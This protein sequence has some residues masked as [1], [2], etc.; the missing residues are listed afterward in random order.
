MARGG[1]P[2]KDLDDWLRA[3]QELKRERAGA[4]TGTTQ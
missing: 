1:R 2:G 3:E 4:S